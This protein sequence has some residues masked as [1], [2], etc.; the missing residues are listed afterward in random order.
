MMSG[1]IPAGFADRYP[2]ELSGGQRQRVNIARALSLDPRIV[3]LDEAVSALDKS[4]E[5][6]ITQSARSAQ[7]SSAT[8]NTL[9]LARSQ[10]SRIH[11]RSRHRDVPGRPWSSRE[12]T[13]VI[14]GRAV[15]P[16]T[17]GVAGIQAH[18]RSADDGPQPCRSRAR[19]PIRCRRPS[20]CRFRT[21]CTFAEG[22]CAASPPRIVPM[23]ADCDA[24]RRLSHGRSVVLALARRDEACMSSEM[25]EPTA[26]IDAPV[27]EVDRTR[28]ELD[29]RGTDLRPVRD[30]SIQLK[31]GETLCIIGES[32]SG[33]SLTLRAL[34][35]LLPQ[36]ARLSGTI[37]FR[38]RDITRLSTEDRRRIRGAQFG[39]IFQEPATALDPVYTIGRQIAEAILAHQDVGT[40][41]AGAT[42][43]RAAGAGLDS[44]RYRA[45]SSA[46]P[47]ELSGGM[48]QRAM[49]AIALACRPDVLLADEPTTALD[50][51]VQMQ[52]LLLLRRIAASA[53]HVG[54]IRDARYRGRR[55]DR[56][57][58][59]RHVC[60]QHRRIRI[61]GAGAADP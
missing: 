39:T 47:H 41:K 28:R 6:Q 18:G 11:L 36:G 60:G 20:G 2:H 45:T 32:G 43:P 14:F 10:R 61:G 7:A 19:R 38:G 8:C 35:G 5:A 44:E 15:H 16:Y 26:S 51:T 49:I 54:D 24:L 55:R 21:R 40:E 29:A 59:R 52:I 53:R 1:S 23:D 25:L 12:S 58:S 46:F 56:R 34:I 37:R 13:R 9:H 31:R 27:I 22:V 3:I 42:R 30:V 33:K 57:S 4:V 50:V 17:R 48:R